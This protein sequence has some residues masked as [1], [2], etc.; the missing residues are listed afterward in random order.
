L[1][2]YATVVV[3]MI[4]SRCYEV[5]FCIPLTI[6]WWTQSCYWRLHV[7]YVYITFWL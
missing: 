5:L 3:G 6:Y 7:W 4:Q 1:K 2:G